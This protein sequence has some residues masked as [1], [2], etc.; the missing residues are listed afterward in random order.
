VI[1]EKLQKKIL[2]EAFAQHSPR[3]E[4]KQHN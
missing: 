3:M 4:M 2:G 1:A